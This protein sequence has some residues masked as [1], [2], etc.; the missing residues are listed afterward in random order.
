MR[1]LFSMNQLI[2][3]HC[4]TSNWVTLLQ[5]LRC[6]RSCISGAIQRKRRDRSGVDTLVRD[7]CCSGTR[8][9]PIRRRTICT[10]NAP[11]WHGDAGLGAWNR[12]TTTEPEEFILDV[13]AWARNQMKMLSQHGEQ[14]CVVVDYIPIWK[15]AEKWSSLSTRCLATIARTGLEPPLLCTESRV[16]VP[17]KYKERTHRKLHL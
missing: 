8:V 14:R 13:E 16:T 12:D 4:Q 11:L 10:G 3:R 9:G 1:G 2:I 5:K 6:G 17:A 7:S 15:R